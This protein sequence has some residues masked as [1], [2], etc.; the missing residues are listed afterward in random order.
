MVCGIQIWDSKVALGKVWTVG[1]MLHNFNQNSL[2][3]CCLIF[4]FMV[5][6][7]EQHS[8]LCASFLYQHVKPYYLSGDIRFGTIQCRK[9]FSEYRHYMYI[10]HSHDLTH[11]QR[12]KG[13]SHLRMKRNE[14]A[15]IANVNGYSTIHSIIHHSLPIAS[16]T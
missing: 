1:G 2:Q 8:V 3:T 10:I 7:L 6:Q 5:M 14:C 9:H 4:E 13:C 12:F 11:I 16:E 15:L